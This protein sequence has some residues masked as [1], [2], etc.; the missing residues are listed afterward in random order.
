[1]LTNRIKRSSILSLPLGLP[2]FETL[3]LVDPIAR[4][5]VYKHFSPSG[6]KEAPSFWKGVNPYASDSIQYHEETERIEGTK[7]PTV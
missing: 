1:M 7:E 2:S 5:A 3:I 6:S 4:R